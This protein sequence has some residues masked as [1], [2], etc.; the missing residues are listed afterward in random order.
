MVQ[1]YQRVD[2]LAA[3]PSARP[4]GAHV[5]PVLPPDQ[6]F[7]FLCRDN[8]TEPFAGD[9]PRAQADFMAD[10]QVPS[11]VDALSGTVSRP[12]WRTKPTW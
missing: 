5:P 12:A 1:S 3:G 10:A 9:L 2:R 6:V 8:F 7:L 4:P 11:G